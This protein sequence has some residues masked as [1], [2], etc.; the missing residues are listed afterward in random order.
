MSSALW[1]GPAVLTFELNSGA[2]AEI[3]NILNIKVKII[4]KLNSFSTSLSVVL[5]PLLPSPSSFARIS[6]RSLSLPLS[7]DTLIYSVHCC[8]NRPLCPGVGIITE[9]P[10]RLIGLEPAITSVLPEYTDTQTQTC[11]HKHTLPPLIQLL[12]SPRKK[13]TLASGFNDTVGAQQTCNE[14]LSPS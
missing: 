4:L 3:F 2:K 11:T 5:P 8:F 9:L 7:L 1:Q 10:S 6:C 12:V 14:M 13:A